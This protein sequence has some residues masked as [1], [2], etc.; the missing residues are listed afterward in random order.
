MASTP[1]K[2]RKDT[3]QQ[4]DESGGIKDEIFT[5]RVLIY[6]ENE[7]S[8]LSRQFILSISL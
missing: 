8:K 3:V 5:L 4:L 1:L 6:A 7:S 2:Y